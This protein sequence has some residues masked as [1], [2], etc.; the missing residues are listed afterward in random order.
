MRGASLAA[1]ALCGLLSVCS[2]H[3]HHRRTTRASHWVK[4]AATT[5]RGGRR[6]NNK[7]TAPSNPVT[8]KVQENIAEPPQQAEQEQE[9]EPPAGMTEAAV[10]AASYIELLGPELLTY[11]ADTGETERLPTAEVLAGKHIALYFTNSVAEDAMARANSNQTDAEAAA[12]PRVLRSATV[13]KAIYNI[14]MQAGHNVEFVYVPLMEEPERAKKNLESMPWVSI[15]PDNNSTA[16]NLIRKTGVTVMPSVVIID[17]KGEVVTRD[18]LSNMAYHPQD[19]PWRNKSL[20]ES[21]GNTFLKSDGSSVGPEALKGKVLGLYFSADWCAPCKQFTPYL[22]EAYEAIKASGK[23]FEIVYVGSDKTEEEQT[24]YTAKMPWLSL[25]FNSRARALVPVI[26]GINALPTLLLFDENNKLISA[27]GRNDVMKD[28]NAETPGA[29]F[30]WRPKPLADLRDS[31]EL[32]SRG[33]VLVVFMDGVDKKAQGPMLETLQPIAEQRIAQLEA[34]ADAGG[35]ALLT[36]PRRVA[37]L[38]ATEIDELSRAIRQLCSLNEIQGKWK[39]MKS[40][41]AL[42]VPRLAL[43]SLTDGAYHLSEDTEVT[44]EAVTS[45]LDEFDKG[46]LRFKRISDGADDEDN[47]DSGDNGD[48]NDSAAQ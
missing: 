19:F 44:P 34:A 26:L 21:L 25:P 20:K 14:T 22:M 13:L 10:N 11:D 12:E 1:V 2:A 45:L 8:D 40:K 47:K 28:A 24:G 29:H 30:P 48:I 3:M 35:A 23:E 7:E 32:L 16:V 4:R 46:T 15:V 31:P 5:I 39:F 27:N 36:A 33:P 37:F 17:P 43:V 6:G 38:A 9:Q 18:G 41:K 42:M